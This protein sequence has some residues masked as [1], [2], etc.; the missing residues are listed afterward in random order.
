MRLGWLMLSLSVP[1]VRF[2]SVIAL[3]FREIDALSGFYCVG[4]VHESLLCL[5]SRGA[6]LRVDVDFAIPLAGFWR[7]GNRCV[8]SWCFI[9]IS[10]C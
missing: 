4:E 2:G 6:F 5:L 10:G 7:I 9:G 1:A 8:S 3:V